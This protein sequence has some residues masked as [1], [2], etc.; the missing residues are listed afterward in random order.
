MLPTTIHI[1][2]DA[3]FSKPH[4]LAVIGHALFEST[5]E[6]ET[7]AISEVKLHIRLIKESNNIRAELRGAIE[8]LRACPKGAIVLL[9]TDAKLSPPSHPD[10]KNSNV[11]IT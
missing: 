4:E 8:A 11:R 9:Y 7:K 5:H 10:E 2:T 6:H 1:Y 3:S